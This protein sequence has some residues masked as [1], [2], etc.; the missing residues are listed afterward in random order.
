MTLCRILWGNEASRVAEFHNPFTR[1]HAETLGVCH[2]VG[3]RGEPPPRRPTTVS[4]LP[5]PA[6]M[7]NRP[8]RNIRRLR[9]A[10]GGIPAALSESSPSLFSRLRTFVT[11]GGSAWPAPHSWVVESVLP[12]CHRLAAPVRFCSHR[13]HQGRGGSLWVSVFSPSPAGS[14]AET[15]SSARAVRCTL[16]GCVELAR[17]RCGWWGHESS[18]RRAELTFHRVRCPRRLRNAH[19]L[20]RT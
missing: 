8:S 19:R 6:P 2:A 7:Q 20:P 9:Q 15:R 1:D 18:A 11:I 12:A 13:R 4:C 16:K 14:R 10:W 17:T 5:L 3:R